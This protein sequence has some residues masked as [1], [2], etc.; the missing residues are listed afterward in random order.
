MFIT[1]QTPLG[2]VIIKVISVGVKL[3][4]WFIRQ[5]EMCTGVLPLSQ[6]IDIERNEQIKYLVTSD[7]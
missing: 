4:C 5:V 7:G 6:S 3:V 2:I 1:F